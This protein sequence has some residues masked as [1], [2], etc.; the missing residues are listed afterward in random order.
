MQN[1]LFCMFVFLLFIFLFLFLTIIL[2][3][4]F[5]FYNVVS[6]NLFLDCMLNI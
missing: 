1:V 5:M 2:F 6:F 4:S 3:I